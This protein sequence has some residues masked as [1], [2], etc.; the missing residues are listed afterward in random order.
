MNNN[1]MNNNDF[2]VEDQLQHDSLFTLSVV[3]DNHTSQIITIV[4]AQTLGCKNLTTQIMLIFAL[5]PAQVF[6]LW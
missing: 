3:E 6:N 4:T 1:V 2:L 5:T